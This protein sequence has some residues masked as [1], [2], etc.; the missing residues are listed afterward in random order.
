MYK[1]IHATQAMVFSFKH[2]T[3]QA[4]LLRWLIET[5]TPVTDLVNRVNN[6]TILAF[7]VIAN[8]N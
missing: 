7:C 8:C 6:A 1:A 5:G 4:I 3:W 2:C